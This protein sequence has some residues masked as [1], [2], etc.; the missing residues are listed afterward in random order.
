[1]TKRTDEIATG[2][3]KIHEGREPPTKGTTRRRPGR[4]PRPVPRGTDREEGPKAETGIQ[5]LVGIVEDRDGTVLTGDKC[6]GK[7]SRERH[8]AK[9]KNKKL[10]A[11]VT[12]HV[13]VFLIFL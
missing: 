4:R 9:K 6:S 11:T 8:R 5:P 7:R 3:A 2:L 10:T 13:M 1:M 12:P